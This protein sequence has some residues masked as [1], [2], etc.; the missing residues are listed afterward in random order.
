MC[1][2]AT[3][4]CRKAD[5]RCPTGYCQKADRGVQQGIA[6]KRT[7]GVRQDIAR[8]R[9]GVSDRILPESGPG[10]P[11]GYC[12]KA[13]RGVR[14]GIARKRTGV[15][16]RGSARKKFSFWLK[17]SPARTQNRLYILKPC[18]LKVNE[19]LSARARFLFRL[20]SAKREPFLQKIPFSVLAEGHF[21]K[22]ENLLLAQDHTGG[23]PHWRRTTPVQDHTGAGPHR[24]RTTL[25]EKSSRHFL[26]YRRNTYM[27]KQEELCLHIPSMTKKYL[28]RNL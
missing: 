27:I 18:C 1:R 4:Y 15:S 20:F 3:G 28:R 25:A 24:R 5:R 9:T 12:R 22:K 11:T 23:G 2:G 21:D 6:R 10:C 19:N 14:Q 26:W 16:D 17:P 7:G 8:K 13:D